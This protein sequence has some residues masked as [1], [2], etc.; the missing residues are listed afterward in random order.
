MSELNRFRIG[1]VKSK[2][3]RSKLSAGCMPTGTLKGLK[4]FITR[5]FAICLQID[6]VVRKVLKSCELK[7]I[8]PTHLKRLTYE[9]NINTI[10]LLYDKRK[11]FK[12]RVS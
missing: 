3:S 10:R 2:S 6:S 9:S 1:D 12:I 7:I 8:H 11:K 5:V 4:G